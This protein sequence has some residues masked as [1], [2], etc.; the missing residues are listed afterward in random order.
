MFLE[1]ERLTIE[2]AKTSE[3]PFYFELFNDPDW[4]RYINDK[5]LKTI[6]ETRVYLDDVLSKN[7]KLKGLGFFSVRLKS[8]NELIGVTT[9]LHRDALAYI[10]IGYGFLPK[11]RGKGFAYEATSLMLSYVQNKF[12]QKKVYALTVPEN[13]RSQKLLKK[14][15]FKF[16]EKKEV[17][18][19]EEDY[20]FE[21]LF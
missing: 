3:A 19:G 13:I 1:S 14:L 4:K 7:K 11:G 2:E 6:E 5:G 20:V 16:V 15:D 17:F 21:Y 10:D 9:A 18:K 12:K 8:S